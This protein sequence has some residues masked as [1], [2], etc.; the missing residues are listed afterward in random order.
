MGK[1]WKQRQKKDEDGHDVNKAKR[2]KKNRIE[3]KVKK[4]K[5]K[6]EEE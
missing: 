4:E 1:K 2:Y 6:K 3:K 5:S